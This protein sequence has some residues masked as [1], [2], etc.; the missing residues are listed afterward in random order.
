MN[1]TPEQIQTLLAAAG[2]LGCHARIQAQPNNGVATTMGV[3]PCTAPKAYKLDV[4]FFGRNPANGQ[5]VTTKIRA[6]VHGDPAAPALVGAAVV[7]EA[8]VTDMANPPTFALAVVGL[9]L[10][11]S[12]NN[13]V[14][15][16]PCDVDAII[17]GP[18]ISS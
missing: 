5:I 3:V 13:P 6:T 7:S 10:V 16:A 2:A 9:N 11:L 15:G 12:V 8:A 17:F 14:A 4:Q 1:F 18:Y